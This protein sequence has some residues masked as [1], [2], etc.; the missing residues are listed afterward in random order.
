MTKLTM[1]IDPSL[2]ADAL[3]GAMTE[4]T[5]ENKELN[6]WGESRAELRRRAEHLAKLQA[7]HLRKIVKQQQQLF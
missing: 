1:P 5:P 2:L 7:A 3:F 4:N 6:H